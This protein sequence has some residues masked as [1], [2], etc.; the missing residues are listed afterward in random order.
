MT[1]TAP[2]PTH[3]SASRRLDSWKEI[4]AYLGRDVRTVQRWERTDDLP[5]R[6]LQHAKLASVYAY[7]NELEAWRESREPAG[8]PVDPVSAD[9]QKSRIPIWLAA[10][11]P[12]VAL[13]S[14]GLWTWSRS[15]VPQP[16]DPSTISTI[17][18]LPIVNFSGDPEQ[19]YFSDAMTDALITQLSTI[20]RLFVISRTSVMTFKNSRQPVRAIAKALNVDAVVEG[21]VTRSAGRV[22]VTAKLI[23]AATDTTL[24]A[25]TFDRDASDVLA[26]QSDVA[27]AIARQVEASL[28]RD[29]LARLTAT[30]TVA[31]DV[32]EHYVKGM[33]LVQNDSRSTVEEAVRHLEA[34]VAGDPTFAPAYVGLASAYNLLG[35]YSLGVRSPAETRPKAAAA[36]TA[37]LKLDP[38]LTGGYTELAYVEQRE[39]RWSAAEAGYRRAIRLSPGDSRAHANLADLLS[40][41]GRFDEAIAL[42]RRARDMDP[43]SVWRATT[44]GMVLYF[45]RRYDEAAHELRAA[46]AR[47][48]EDATAHWYLGNV[49]MAT[50]RFDEAIESLERSVAGQR[51]PGPLGFLASAYA[52][53]GRFHDA[54]R[55]VDELSRLAQRSYVPPAAFVVAYS[56]LGDRERAFAALEQ[57]YEERSNLI[58]S[59]KVLPVLD[60][61]RD[62]PRFTAMVRRVGLE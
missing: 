29:D 12:I 48:P 52:K 13:F 53:A 39:W 32:F 14:V 62:D 58:R 1:N 11:V 43:L 18:V 42:A 9:P 56:G 45:A 17:A 50:S 30:R 51:N 19:E 35:T 15:G 28:S 57:A 5:V 16:A 47:H 55:V 34:A 22:R 26:L 6:R 38:N 37:A 7:T 31:A 2:D 54:E 27:E 36:A 59:L 20:P 8:T 21:S 49:L 61:L 40:C 4:A 10:L 24:W 46:T 44:L 33:A 25:Q 60:P 41:Q 23:R 3:H